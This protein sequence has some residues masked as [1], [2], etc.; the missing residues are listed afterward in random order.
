MTSIVADTL[1]GDVAVVEKCFLS[2][3]K[4]TLPKTS[5]APSLSNVSR[6]RRPYSAP[7]APGSGNPAENGREATAIHYE[8]L[9][10]FSLHS[11][12]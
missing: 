11:E 4:L 7:T 6:L 12:F 10:P 2:E 5:T 3:I 1:F 9:V 8:L